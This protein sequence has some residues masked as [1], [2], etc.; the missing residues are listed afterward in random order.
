MSGKRFLRLFAVTFV[1]VLALGCV[2][3]QGCK[4][5]SSSTGT[6]TSTSQVASPTPTPANST[7]SAEDQC[8]GDDKPVTNPK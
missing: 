3:L 6:T 7:P 1:L 5:T 8:F 2:M 4:K